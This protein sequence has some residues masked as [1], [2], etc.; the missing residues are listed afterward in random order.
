MASK[1]IQIGWYNIA[2]SW[3][4]LSVLRW[5]YLTFYANR[6]FMCTAPE[7]PASCPWEQQSLWE[8]K[9]ILMQM[10]I[11]HI[12]EYLCYAWAT[13]GVLAS[14]KAQPSC[15]TSRQH[16]KASSI[17]LFKF[18]FFLFFIWAYT[19]PDCLLFWHFISCP[20][21]S[22][23]ARLTCTNLKTLNYHEVCCILSGEIDRFLL[24]SSSNQHLRTRSLWKLLNK[25][26]IR[27]ISE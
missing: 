13:A 11:S 9:W 4:R 3:G 12:Q 18:F 25:S 27:I 22:T 5:E 6:A 19:L 24:Y 1:T 23:F 20:V 21:L 8:D 10:L 26:E 16:K 14:P 17:W 7:N 15:L 2:E